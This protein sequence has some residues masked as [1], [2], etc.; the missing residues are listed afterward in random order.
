MTLLAKTHLNNLLRQQL[1]IYEEN[2]Q[3]VVA[4][5]NNMMTIGL[6]A[7]NAFESQ[8]AKNVHDNSFLYFSTPVVPIILD[9]QTFCA[10]AH[11]L[12]FFIKN[13]TLLLTVGRSSLFVHLLTIH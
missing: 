3:D 1:I 2:Q 6:D 8:V 13:I 5:Q 10:E 7:G 11:Y 4:H 12:I 9:L